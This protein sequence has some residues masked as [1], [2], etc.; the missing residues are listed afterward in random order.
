MLLPIIGALAGGALNAFGNASERKTVNDRLNSLIETFRNSYMTE[1]KV[2]GDVRRISGMFNNN[3]TNA[4]NTAAFRSRGIVNSNVVKG[5]VIANSESA[6]LGAVQNVYNQA[7]SYNTQITDKIAQLESSKATGSQTADF[8]GGA[9]QG[10]IAGAQVENLTSSPSTNNQDGLGFWDSI[11]TELGIDT[12]DTNELTATP[13]MPGISSGASIGDMLSVSPLN[14]HPKDIKSLLEYMIDATKS[15]E[16]QP[17]SSKSSP[18]NRSSSGNIW[19]SKMLDPNFR[20]FSA[21]SY[22]GVI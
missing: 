18:S 3:L 1:N 6:K 16:Q 13:S 5:G 7:R 19:N 20:Y 12:I 8:V 15:K 21:P 2:Q 9:I 10:G 14:E 17:I 4:L 22:P 11:K